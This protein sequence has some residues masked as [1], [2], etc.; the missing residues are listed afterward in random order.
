MPVKN[1]SLLLQ[2]PYTAYNRYFLFPFLLWA[3]AGAILLLIYDSKVLFTTVNAHHTPLLDTI[4]LGL[5]NLGDGTFISIILLILLARPRLRN[6]WYFLAAVACNAL[7]ALIIQVVKGIVNAPRPLE[8]FKDDAGWIHIQE[9][10]PHLY[11]HSFPSGHSAGAFSLFCFLS[12]LLPKKYAPWGIVFF[13]IA[14]L[15]AYTRPYLAAHFYADIY[16]GSLLGTACTLV[17]MAIMRHYQPRF[18]REG[19]AD[20]TTI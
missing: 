5:T 3:L 9:T 16:V 20:S 4:M 2:K 13:A 6:W 8:Y 12:M 10:W 17:F 18:F 11:H 7:P 14:L 19:A 15:V 1:N